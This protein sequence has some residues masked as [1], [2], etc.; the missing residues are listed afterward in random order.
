MNLA[1]KEERPQKTF[2]PEPQKQYKS[3]KVDW[4]KVEIDVSA[5][6]PHGKY[7]GKTLGWIIEHDDNYS[8]WMYS[9]GIIAS[10]GLLKKKELPKVLHQENQNDQRTGEIWIAIYE[11]LGTG[12][13]SPFL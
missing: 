8:G 3:V 2:A 9:N 6:I 13:P 12:I 7:Q 4:S 11:L 5:E 1:R 10:W